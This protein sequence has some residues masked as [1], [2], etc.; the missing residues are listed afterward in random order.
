MKKLLFFSGK[1]FNAEGLVVIKVES[2]T[3]I[4]SNY[5]NYSYT[6][7]LAYANMDNIINKFFIKFSYFKKYLIYLL[8]I[9]I[10]ITVYF[11]VS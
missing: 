8:I 1:K 7:N 9:A 6:Q 5:T 11:V 3:L 2:I 4:L 10:L